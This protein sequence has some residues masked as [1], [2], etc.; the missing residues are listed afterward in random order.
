MKFY[1]LTQAQVIVEPTPN[2]NVLVYEI[3]DVVFIEIRKANENIT[4]SA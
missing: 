4:A 1:D 3:D 2:N